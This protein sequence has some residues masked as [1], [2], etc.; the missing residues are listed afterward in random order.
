MA[1]PTYYMIEHRKLTLSATPN[2]K[3]RC[4]NECFH[5]NDWKEVWTEWGWLNLKLTLEEAKR[6]LGYWENL[7]AYA[8]RERKTKADSQYRISV[9][10]VYDGTW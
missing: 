9:D 8:V 1:T 2:S 3:R 4:Y 5:P 10:N 6:K 7:S